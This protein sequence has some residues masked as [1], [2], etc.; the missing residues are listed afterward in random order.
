MH[1]DKIIKPAFSVVG[2]EGSTKDG[3]GFIGR[4]WEYANNHFGAVINLAAKDEAGNF[5]GFWGAMTDFSR[6]FRPWE[7]GFSEG[8]YLAGVECAPDTEAP[9]GWTRWDIPGFEYLRA[10]A[11][12]P[13]TFGD[14]IAYM[15]EN[16]MDLIGAVQDF[17]DPMTGKCYMLFPIGRM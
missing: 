17:T 15:R 2:R 12:S 6:S 14:T 4:L 13:T 10:E 1:I 5:K 16:G 11:D 3:E 7:N 9:E 8:L